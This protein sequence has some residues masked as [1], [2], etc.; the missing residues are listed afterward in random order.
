MGRV[1]SCPVRVGLGGWG[2]VVRK[3]VCVVMIYASRAAWRDITF[4]LL[5]TEVPLP[6]FLLNAAVNSGGHA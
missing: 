1:G 6:F 4:D 3:C 5:I 2:V